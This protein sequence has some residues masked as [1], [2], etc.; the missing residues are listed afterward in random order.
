MSQ[1]W[2]ATGRHTIESDLLFPKL[3]EGSEHLVFLDDGQECLENHIFRCR[4]QGLT[5]KTVRRGI[6]LISAPAVEK[7]IL[8]RPARFGITN[9]G[10]IIS[11]Q[12]L[13]PEKMPSPGRRRSFLSERPAAVRHSSGFGRKHI[14]DF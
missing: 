2:V 10:Q 1:K 6:I 7:A 8:V 4:R 5:R 9:C 11:S 14:H 3:A 12:K 13:S